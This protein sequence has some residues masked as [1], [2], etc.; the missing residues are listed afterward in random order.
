MKIFRN[1]S[2]IL[3]ADI[4]GSHISAAIVD[5]FIAEILPGS[6]LRRSVNAH[7]EA[8]DI[9]FTWTSALKSVIENSEKKPDYLSVS[10]PGPF[11]Y[12]NG[13]SLIKGMNK[14]ESLY[15]ISIKQVL[16]EALGLSSDS[17]SFT[18]DAEAFLKGEAEHGAGRGFDRILG[19]TLGTGLGSAIFCDGI[20]EDKNLGSSAFNGCI[21]EDF[22]STR[23][24]LNYYKSLGGNRAE[25]I[26]ALAELV[27][28]DPAA[29]KAFNKLAS[30]LSDFFSLHLPHYQSDLI[31][32]G[33]NISK[34]S[35]LFLPKLERDLEN[36]G[37]H[38]PIR[39]AELGEVAAKLGAA[40]HFKDKSIKFNP[41]HAD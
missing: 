23:G 13:I 34:A 37:I 41:E 7:S 1:N 31:L 40:A 6:L 22:I 35:H 33:G 26:K 25:D 14:Y 11:D 8:Q 29:G 17:I 36:K 30:W 28:E 9:L 12:K 32:I 18:N 20:S 15:G 2:V 4:G 16:A 3:S 21:A 5:P 39:I 10:M 19:I 38:I 27:S 24:L